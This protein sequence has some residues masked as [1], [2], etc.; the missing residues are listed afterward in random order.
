MISSNAIDVHHLAKQYGK[1]TAV[2]DLTLQVAR[3]EIFGFLGPNGA[4]KTTSVKMLVGLARPTGGGGRLLGAPIGDRH[5]R[6]K[7]GYLPELFRYQEWLTAREVLRLHC[8]LA[9]L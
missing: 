6:K 3:G 4:G 8:R 5:A 2:A 7:L 9:G 1:L